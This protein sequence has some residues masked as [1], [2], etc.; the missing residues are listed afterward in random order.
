MKGPPNALREVEIG[1]GTYKSMQGRGYMTQ[2][3]KMLCQWAT[4]QHNIHWV[5]AE[6]HEQN[7][8]S[9]KVC[10][11]NGFVHYKTLNDWYWWRKSVKDNSL[12]IPQT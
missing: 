11:R 12:D 3:V 5:K 6:T 10:K 7:I 1:Y 9:Q 2:A 8:A 4:Q